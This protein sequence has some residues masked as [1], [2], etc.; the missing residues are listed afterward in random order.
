MISYHLTPS[1]RQDVLEIYDYIAADNPDAAD[2]FVD[3]LYQ[4]FDHL[5]TFPRSGHPRVD[6]AGPR[7][8]LF[9]PVGAYLII[10]HAHHEPLEILAVAH[11]ARDIPTLLRHR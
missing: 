7:P 9:W 10:Y 11:A 2:R 1:A 4:A 8:V 6:L 3:E 5:A